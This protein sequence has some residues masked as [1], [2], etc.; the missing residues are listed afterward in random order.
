MQL[1]IQTKERKTA[2]KQVQTNNK[3]IQI[4][5]SKHKIVSMP[6]FIKIMIIPPVGTM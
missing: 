5:G 1:V 6:N 2:S 4:K 3:G